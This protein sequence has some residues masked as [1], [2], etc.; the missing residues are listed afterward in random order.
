MRILC[1]LANHR[2]RA[3]LEQ[4]STGASRQLSG[5][6][7][8]SC[9][10]NARLDESNLLCRDVKI[11]QVRSYLKHPACVLKLLLPSRLESGNETANDNYY[12]VILD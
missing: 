11:N 1:E 8:I 12:Y 4:A 5:I 7:K 2:H 10:L 6:A 3:V 9:F